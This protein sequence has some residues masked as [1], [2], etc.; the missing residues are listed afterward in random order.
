MIS[1]ATSGEYKYGFTTDIDTHIIPKGLN[2]DVVRMIS[3][4]KGEPEWL[5]EFRLKAYRYWETL[6]MPDWAHLSIPPIDYQAIS[7][8]AE[9]QQKKKGPESLDEVDPE[10]LD[11]FNRLGIPLQE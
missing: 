2:E 6:E 4:R 9:P 7:Y 10:L 5:L 3:E 8:Y 11:T 1:R